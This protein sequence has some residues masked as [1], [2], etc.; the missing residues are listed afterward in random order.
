MKYSIVFFI[1]GIA[2]CCT[3]QESFDRESL[4]LRTLASE[5]KAAQELYDH[6]RAHTERKGA[7]FYWGHVVNRLKKGSVSIEELA[8]LRLE[9]IA[10]WE[11]ASK[12]ESKK[13]DHIGISNSLLISGRPEEALFWRV[14]YNKKRGMKETEEKY[15]LL[16]EPERLNELEKAIF[17]SGV[18]FPFSGVP[19]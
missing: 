15:G 1:I 6:Y 12:V 9:I 4:L 13:F 14:E 5:A 16:I 7:A 17:A 8:K 2:C 11:K 19:E 18:E 10:D 3:P